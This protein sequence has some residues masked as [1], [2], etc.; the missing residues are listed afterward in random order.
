MVLVREWVVI[1]KMRG[2][3][4]GQ[5]VYHV[6]SDLN[7]KTGKRETRRN[8]VH[9][10]GEIRKLQQELPVE[11]QETP[12]SAI[13]DTPM[14]E[15]LAT[16]GVAIFSG[17][18]ECPEGVVPKHWSHNIRLAKK[19][20]RKRRL[21]RDQWSLGDTCSAIIPRRRMNGRV[22]QVLCKTCHTP[23]LIGYFVYGH[24][25]TRRRKFCKD[26]CKMRMRQ[27]QMQP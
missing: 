15:M 9:R 13:K 22:R 14:R 6:R 8:W 3:R 16:L 21:T 7:R 5:R 23:L 27:S 1:A 2:E 26:A 17:K 4:G 11:R 19:W 25:I 20:L 12:I 24:K 10:R 18:Q